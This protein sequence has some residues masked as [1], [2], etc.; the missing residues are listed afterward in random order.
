MHF[1]WMPLNIVPLKHPIFC[2]PSHNHSCAIDYFFLHVFPIP[3]SFS[4]G[5]YALGHFLMHLLRFLGCKKRPRRHFVHVTPPTAISQ[6]S[7]CLLVSQI[8]S[9]PC[10]GHEKC[11]KHSRPFFPLPNPCNPVS[12]N[13][14]PATQAPFSKYLLALQ[15]EH[16]NPS[17]SASNIHATQFLSGHLHFPS[18][19]A[20]FLFATHWNGCSQERIPLHPGVDPTLAIPGSQLVLHDSEEKKNFLLHESTL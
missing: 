5:R 14:Q 4:A 8:Q 7:Q 9:A 12:E 17:P 10:C 2:S 16:F 3:S 13:L 11:L 15:R 6:A 18:P 19:G 20:T 1:I